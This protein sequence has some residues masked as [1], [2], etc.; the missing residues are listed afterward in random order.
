[1]FVIGH[2]LQTLARLLHFVFQI[3]VVVFLA[4][5]VLSWFAPD[6]RQPFIGFIYRI[7]DPVLDRIRRV[8]PPVGA[9][10]LS[11]VIAIAFFWFLD[12]FLVPSLRDAGYH[13]LK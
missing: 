2:L 9:F 12:S 5:A 6:P 4:R 8:V 11:P 13:L 3:A 1:M 10:D 7:S